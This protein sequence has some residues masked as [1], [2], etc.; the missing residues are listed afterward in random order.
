MPN[1]ITV[2]YLD[3]NGEKATHPYFVDPAVIATSA[4]AI[5]TFLQALGGVSDAGIPGFSLL[6]Q[7]EYTDTLGTGPYDIEDK[8]VMSFRD[9]LNNVVRIAVP[10]PIRTLMEGDDESFDKAEVAVD[11]IITEVLTYLVSKGSEALIE[12]IRSKR[13]R[14]NRAS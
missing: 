1:K 13:Q 8:M 5:E 10:A 6:S 2:Q 7:V 11:D 4:P 12:Y 3:D 9:S 14:K